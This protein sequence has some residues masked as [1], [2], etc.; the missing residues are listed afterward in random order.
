MILLRGADF[1][2]APRLHPHFLSPTALP[3]S[4]IP[5]WALAHAHATATAG[6][7]SLTLDLANP[8]QPLRM[9][10]QSTGLQWQAIAFTPHP[11]HRF[12]IEEAYVRGND[13][14]VRYRQ[15]ADDVFAF[16]LNYRLLIDS[17]DILGIELWISIQTDH[18][19]TTPWLE[20]SSELAGANWQSL[21][22]DELMTSKSGLPEPESIQ[23]GE[24]QVAAL[25]ACPS[26]A[27]STCVWLIEPRDQ[28]QFQLTSDLNAS[29]QHAKLFG[30]F[31]EKGV[32]RRARLRLMLIGNAFNPQQV[33]ELYQDFANSPLP[34]TA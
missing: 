26:N 31:M 15:S 2:F 23:P 22:H 14:I 32:I 6:R 30:A 4:T 5:S 27:P 29:E 16:Q 20:L 3:M 7:L 24:A 13:L 28:V 10:D 34:L 18:L 19:D 33:K 1:Q 9:Y 11:S 25:A 17:S 12:E 8:Q 21:R